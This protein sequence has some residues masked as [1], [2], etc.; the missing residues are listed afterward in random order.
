MEPP[1]YSEIDMQ[2]SKSRKKDDTVFFS[3]NSSDSSDW[4]GNL[5]RHVSIVLD[6]SEALHSPTLPSGLVVAE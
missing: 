5:P 3:Q 2:R 6:F 1:E 4:R